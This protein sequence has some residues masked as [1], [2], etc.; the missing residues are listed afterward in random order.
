MKWEG[1]LDET[2]LQQVLAGKVEPSLARLGPAVAP[3][4]GADIRAASA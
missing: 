1:A 3:H 2:R 4:N